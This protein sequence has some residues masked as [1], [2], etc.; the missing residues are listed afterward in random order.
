MMIKSSVSENENPNKNKCHFIKKGVGKS[1]NPL[2]RER[3]VI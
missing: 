1:Q 2:A 3:K